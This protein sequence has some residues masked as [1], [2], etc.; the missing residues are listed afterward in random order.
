MGRF[1]VTIWD[2]RSVVWGE[3]KRSENGR[4]KTRQIKLRIA[5]ISLLNQN[6]KKI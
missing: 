1:V 2:A 6:S 4:K 5:I 3:M